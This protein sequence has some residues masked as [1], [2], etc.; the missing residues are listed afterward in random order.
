MLPEEGETIHTLGKIEA[1]HQF[2]VG[3]V[4]LLVAPQLRRL[5]NQEN[6]VRR[7][8]SHRHNIWH[9]QEAKDSKLQIMGQL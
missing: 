5:R 6:A 8:Q 4:H 2:E 9:A 3:Q 7:D 1:R